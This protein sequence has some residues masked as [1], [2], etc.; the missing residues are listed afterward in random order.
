MLLQNKS[1]QTGKCHFSFDE[2]LMVEINIQ[3]FIHLKR[4]LIPSHFNRSYFKGV[5]AHRW[6]KNMSKVFGTFLSYSFFFSLSSRQDNDP[7]LPLSILKT[8]MRQIG[9]RER[10]YPRGHSGRP[11][12]DFTLEMCL[13]PNCNGWKQSLSLH[14]IALTL[15]S[16]H[17]TQ[18][19]CLS[20]IQFISW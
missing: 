6:S 5:L 4:V 13:I 12:L 14:S 16:P 3:F 15:F 2:L 18:P 7:L 20:L 9:L 19:V 1:V 8:M 11:F 10:N 17:A